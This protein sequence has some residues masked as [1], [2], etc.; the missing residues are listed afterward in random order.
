M[1]RKSSRSVDN[2][3]E[4]M[5]VEY[6]YKLS[7]EQQDF[8]KDKWRDLK[9]MLRLTQQCYKDELL[10]VNSV[11][12]DNVR[13]YLIRLKK[14]EKGQVSESFNFTDQEIEYILNKADSLGALD[15]CKS[16]FPNSP[17]NDLVKQSQTAANLIKSLEGE[18]PTVLDYNNSKELKEYIPPYSDAKVLAKINQAD[19]NVELNIAKLDSRQKLMIK[20]LKHNMRAPRFISTGNSIKS[21]VLRDLFEME[22]IRATYDKP[23][24][25]TDEV[26]AYIS[27]CNEY[28]ISTMLSEQLSDLNE[29]LAEAV[30]SE[31]RGT[32]HKNISDSR[33]AIAKEYN[34]CQ[35]RINTLQ[36]DLNSRRMARIGADNLANESLSK[37]IDLVEMEEDRMKLLRLMEARNIAIEKEIRKIESF[38]ELI[39]EF[40]G[41]SATELL[42]F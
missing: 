1:E 39:A 4:T 37:W 8:L 13:K 30:H 9:D 22:F 25:N 31:D 28:V 41:V 3:A 42:N 38:D 34:D 24:L 27:L 19:H 2:K 6:K 32:F 10:D 11:E 36:V 14:I 5:V 33:I 12:Y 23:D 15:I 20:S 16:L 26:S 7:P 40:H 18:I 17:A 35:R 29:K 21:Q